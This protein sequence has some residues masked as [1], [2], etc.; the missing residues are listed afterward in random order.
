MDPTVH[1]VVVVNVYGISMTDIQKIKGLWTKG[2]TNGNYFNFLRPTFL[3]SKSY[4]KIKITDDESFTFESDLLRFL[5]TL[6]SFF[7]F[8]PTSLPVLPLLGITRV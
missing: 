5:Y 7:F 2:E 3:Y 8:C 4:Q 1:R 6:L